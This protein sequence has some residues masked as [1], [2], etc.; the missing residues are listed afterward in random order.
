MKIPLQV[1]FHGMAPSEAL[2]SAAR[3]KAEKLER[4]SA[5]IISCRVDVDELQK[6]QQQGRPFGVRIHLSLPGDELTVD[7]VT[8]EDAHVA[9][10][11][12]FDS[13]RRQIE[14]KVRRQRGQRKH[15]PT[16]LHGEVVRLDAGSRSGFIRTAEEDEYRFDSDNVVDDAYDRLEVG[17]QV[18]FLPELAGQGRQAKRVS[19]GKHGF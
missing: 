13:M 4:F 10:R 5:D 3:M 15:H 12:A 19:A 14:D 7:R 2:E 18:Q 6:H 11:D 1:V 9:L 17:A 8:D 16:P